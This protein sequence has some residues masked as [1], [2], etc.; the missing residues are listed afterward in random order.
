MQVFIKNLQGT[1][2][3]KFDCFLHASYLGKHFT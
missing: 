3:D 1:E 2:I